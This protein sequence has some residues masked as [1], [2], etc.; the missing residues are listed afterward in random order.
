MAFSVWCVVSFAHV[1]FHHQ[2]TARPLHLHTEHI[3]FDCS[4]FF[5]LFA[6][7]RSCWWAI[8]S[9]LAGALCVCWLRTHP[10]THSVITNFKIAICDALCLW[11][12]EPSV[13]FFSSARLLFGGLLD[14]GRCN[15]VDSFRFKRREF[16]CANFMDGIFAYKR[17]VGNV[18]HLPDFDRPT[19]LPEQIR[20]AAGI[21]IIFHKSVIQR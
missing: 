14:S 16:G 8:H 15:C 20:G 11:R 6:R 10:P 12:D 2:F 3:R 13:R 1:F 21:F 18:W 17:F 19:L 5:Q 4:E 7:S 9:V